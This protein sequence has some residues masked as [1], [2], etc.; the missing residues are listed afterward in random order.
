MKK[1]FT[2][3][4]FLAMIIGIG[5]NVEATTFTSRLSNIAGVPTARG[6]SVGTWGARATWYDLTGVSDTTTL[7]LPTPNDDV[8][9]STGDS[10]VTSATAGCNNM[11][12][13]GTFYNGGTFYVNGTATVNSGGVFNMHSTLYAYNISNSGKFW[14]PSQGYGGSP[15]SLY[16]GCGCT[17]TSPATFTNAFGTANYTLQNDGIFGSTVAQA[18]ASSGN[19]GSGIYIYYSNLANSVTI[20]PS[21]PS[22]TNYVFTVGALAPF[23]TSSSS[24]QNST[25]NINESIAL[26]RYSTVLCF[27]LQNGDAF[28][29]K[30]TC[31]IASGVTVTIAGSF[32][33]R[34]SAPAVSQGNMTYNING[35]LDFA[36]TA[37][38]NTTNELNLASASTANDTTTVNVNN[39]GLLIIGKA[40]KLI[41]S[42]AT[43][44]AL[45]F[46]PMAGSSV[47]FGQPT[48]L[49]VA[50]PNYIDKCIA[51]KLY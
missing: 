23:N 35:T 51:I 13:A 36:S 39:G 6:Y 44:Q 24:T 7:A 42:A 49:T 17:F 25:L 29:G 22:V 21:S 32:H 26:L 19:G 5:S 33:V 31:N 27:S 18:Y 2:F 4:I 1:L 14:N 12:V 20:Q 28:S 41:A 48:G 9:I 3:G 37:T 16:L 46:N 40:L 47:I 8:L 34:G 50:T 30:R 15:K 43:G 11:T 10:V 45:V 38:S